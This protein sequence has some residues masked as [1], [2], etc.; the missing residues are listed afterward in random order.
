MEGGAQHQK[1]QFK[2]VNE[3]EK[4]NKEDEV[5]QNRY[6]RVQGTLSAGGPPEEE[7]CTSFDSTRLL[8]QLL[9]NSCCS[10]VTSQQKISRPL[11]LTVLVRGTSFPPRHDDMHTRC[12]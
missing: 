6:I 5:Q 7:F 10:V 9:N 1:K 12:S 4:K 3:A 11:L 2:V 8:Q